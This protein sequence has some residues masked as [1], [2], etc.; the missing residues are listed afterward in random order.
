M[1][2]LEI[3]F[4]RKGRGDPGWAEYIGEK[5]GYIINYAA[6]PPP[7]EI[8]IINNAANETRIPRNHK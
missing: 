5:G 4:W 2:L 7:R 8:V 1:Q 6:N 3:C